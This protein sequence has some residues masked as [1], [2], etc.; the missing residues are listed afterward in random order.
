MGALYCAGDG[1]L[2]N[3]NPANP[4]D[5]SGDYGEVGNLPSGLGI[6]R[7]LTSHAGALYCADS[8]GLWRLNP[9]NPSDTSGVYGLVGSLVSSSPR[10]L[11]SLEGDLYFLS[12]TKLYR[13]NPSDP[14]DA[15]GDFGDL[16]NLP[17]GLSGGSTVGPR[18]LTA[19]DGGLL[20]ISDATDSI[21]RL[22]PD[23]LDNRLRPGWVTRVGSRHT[24][25]RSTPWTIAVTSYGASIR[26]ISSIRRASTARL[27]IS[28]PG[29]TARRG[30]YRTK[31]RYWPWA[32]ASS[33]ASTRT[34]PAPAPEITGPGD[35]SRLAWGRGRKKD[36]Q[37]TKG[38]CYVLPP[39]AGCGTSTLRTLLTIAVITGSWGIFQP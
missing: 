12:T 5:T 33:G 39:L 7:A 19:L 22:D 25:A 36:S 24:M 28:R 17:S 35:H 9:S 18:G 1:K 6:P 37:L 27:G 3:I 13:V 14:S 15:S 38:C 23:Q 26:M 30:S 21:W 34:T 20:C 11:A 29:W 2:W 8:T 4:S 32:T 31:A 16:G 10:G